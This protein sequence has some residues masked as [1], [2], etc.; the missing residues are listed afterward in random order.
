MTESSGRNNTDAV[1]AA[2]TFLL[3]PTHGL[4][5]PGTA[6]HIKN[7][8]ISHSGINGLQKMMP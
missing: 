7:R 4:Y 1:Q 5:P 6:Y 3:H 2:L 8:F